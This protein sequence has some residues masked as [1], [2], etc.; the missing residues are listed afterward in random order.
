MNVREVDGQEHHVLGGFGVTAALSPEDFG[1]VTLTR[2]SFVPV[3]DPLR[4]VAAEPSLN[5]LARARTS[6]VGRAFLY[7][8]RDLLD[9]LHSAAN[10][11]VRPKANPPSPPPSLQADSADASTR[12]DRMTARVL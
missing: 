5:R 8:H 6:R 7:R 12:S 9:A 4:K 2:V 10:P 3:V 1:L 11:P